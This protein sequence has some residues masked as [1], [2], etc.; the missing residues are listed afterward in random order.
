MGLEYAF[1]QFFSKLY[2]RMIKWAKHPHAP[3]YLAGL[4]FAESSV[5]PIPPDFMLA[6]MALAKPIKAWQY[7]LIATT[8]STLGGILGY[9]L[10]MFC[11]K[12]IYPLFIKFGYATTYQQ[13]EHWF[14]LWDFW[15]IF[16]AGFTPIPYKLFTVAA[17]AASMPLAPFIL[18]SLVGRGGRFFLVAA[19]IRRNGSKMET[20]IYKYIDRAGWLLMASILLA[21]I[22]S[23]VLRHFYY[24][25]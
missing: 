21:Y 12:L 13:V 16:L 8:S 14:L 18:G 4:S 7:A 22:F 9:I 17:G 19:L 2:Q 6:P 10:G 1:M 20:L 11:I 15:I 5:F 24:S 25:G 23:R 3:F